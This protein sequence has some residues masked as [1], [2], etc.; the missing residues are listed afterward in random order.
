MLFAELK[1]WKLGAGDLQ[2]SASSIQG[3]RMGCPTMA[4]FWRRATN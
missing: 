2:Q 3:W 4:E 1:L